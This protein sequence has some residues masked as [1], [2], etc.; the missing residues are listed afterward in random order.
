MS[1]RSSGGDAR[2]R[3]IGAFASAG[4]AHYPMITERLPDGTARRLDTI[5]S[6]LMSATAT[7]EMPA[8]LVERLVNVLE[9]ME[10]ERLIED[11]T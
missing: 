6:P 10:T 11:D 1:A 7:I 3:E 5:A 8:S 2:R 4:D 9:R